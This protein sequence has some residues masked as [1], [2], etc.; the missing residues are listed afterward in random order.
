M[1]R[2][3]LA[4][5]FALV[6]ASSFGQAQRTVQLDTINVRGIV[7][8]SD[9]KPASA[10]VLTCLG[11]SYNIDDSAHG[12]VRHV[13]T[14]TTGRFEFKGVKFDDTLTVESIKYYGKHPVS[15]SRFIVVNLPAPKQAV[16]TSSIVTAKR[17][18]SKPLGKFKLKETF[19]DEI[20]YEATVSRLPIFRD[21]KGTFAEYIQSKLTY[22]EKAIKSNIE[23]TVEIAF[24]IERDGFVRNVRLIRGIG[25]GC[26]EE[27]MKAVAKSPAWKPGA[28]FGHPESLTQTVMI[29]FKLTDK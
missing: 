11:P 8:T 4:I 6:S 16:S 12:F 14:D 24:D 27:V 21:G 1:K 29:Q 9:G 23:G 17:R 22:P 3:L 10:I 28:A 5:V 25:Y 2:L 15:G 7:Y 13:R 20:N 19:I 26:D 18:R